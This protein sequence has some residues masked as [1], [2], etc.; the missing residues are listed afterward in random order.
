MME[1]LSTDEAIALKSTDSEDINGEINVHMIEK[2]EKTLRETKD[3]IF[4]AMA[5]G[6]SFSFTYSLRSVIFVLY[7]ESFDDCPNTSAISI[8][9]YSSYFACAIFAPIYGYFGDDWRFDNL[10]VI[11][12]LID[13]ITFWLEAFTPS[14][15]LL[16]IVYS[17]GG[18]P[19][20]VLIQGYLLKLLPIANARKEQTTYL[21]FYNIGYLLGPAIGGIV[22]A[23][24]SYRAV[25]Y[26]AG[27]ISSLCFI[28]CLIN[29]LNK[30]TN[31]IKKQFDFRQLY[32]NHPI[33]LDIDKEA[34]ATA[35]ATATSTQTAKIL[36]SNEHRF[37]LVLAESNHNDYD[38]DYDD[39]I[40][41]NINSTIL[42]SMACSSNISF[43]VS[44]VTWLVGITLGIQWSSETAMVFWYV[45]YMKDT[46]SQSVAI[47]ALQLCNLVLFSTISVIFGGMFYSKLQRK[48]DNNEKI[49][50]NLFHLSSNKYDFNHFYFVIIQ[51]CCILY[52]G[53]IFGLT[54]DNGLNIDVE[55]SFFIYCAIS[56]ILFANTWF[57]QNYIVSE[58]TPKELTGKFKG[59]RS[60]ISYILRGFGA[61]AVGVLQNYFN[62]EN[63]LWYYIGCCYLTISLITIVVAFLECIKRK[64]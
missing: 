29:V 45:K 6:L 9:L 15:I 16:A 33:A 62:D 54:I 25:F 42:E 20:Q 12:A 50:F 35:T 36:L 55:I 8:V 22:A 34:T 41:T 48:R 40:N 46:Y 49:F 17:L 1:E 60:T 23:Y 10:I 51:L 56:G 2:H 11:A 27:I 47:S 3:V 19:L 58:I 21:L 7:A 43:R 4:K 14:F 13:V 5:I 63:W 64:S 30:Q 52:L 32:I 39:D 26:I 28:Y 18:Q 57:P 44:V 61:L 31:I 53:L 38:D 59:L 37:P 24:T